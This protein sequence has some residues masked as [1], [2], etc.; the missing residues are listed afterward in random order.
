MLDLPHHTA[1]LS[2]GNSPVSLLRL[3]EHTER[4][5]SRRREITREIKKVSGET[6]TTSVVSIGLS[7]LRKFLL[8]EPSCD[9]NRAKKCIY[10]ARKR[11]GG[12]AFL[13][14][15]IFSTFNLPWSASEI[16]AVKMSVFQG[17]SLASP[18]TAYSKKRIYCRNIEISP[19]L[20]RY[21]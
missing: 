16:Q 20:K 4:I 13:Q 17:I 9:S 18:F 2:E 21:L 14:T 1:S 8:T 3:V 19:I 15:C 10:C 7:A 5:V 11:A 6:W 12:S